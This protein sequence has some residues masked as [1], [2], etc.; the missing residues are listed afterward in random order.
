MSF[1]AKKPAPLQA[2]SAVATR[3]PSVTRLGGA[4]AIRVDSGTGM[5]ADNNVAA[6]ARL[7]LGFEGHMPNNAAR[8]AFEGF[9]G[10]EVVRRALAALRDDTNNEDEPGN[11]DK[12]DGL[13]VTQDN[14]T[15]DNE[16][17]G[18]K[19]PKVQQG[20]GR[21][22]HQKTHEEADAQMGLGR[23]GREGPGPQGQASGRRRGLGAGQ[24][25]LLCGRSEEAQPRGPPGRWDAQSPGA[26]SVAWLGGIVWACHKRQNKGENRTGRKRCQF[27]IGHPDAQPCG[28]PG[29]WDA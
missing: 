21:E 23:R 24:G 7:A 25:G 6:G 1:G 13:V 8:D 19:A 9:P 20:S 14:D 16:T 28:P 26:D 4:G 2:S 15:E 18:G 10:V 29:R 17:L 27:F 5:C 12:E 3:G 22:A 11:D